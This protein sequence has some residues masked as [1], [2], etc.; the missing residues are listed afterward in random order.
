MLNGQAKPAPSSSVH[1]MNVAISVHD[2]SF[3]PT[4]AV[5]L[6]QFLVGGDTIVS[7]R[8]RGVQRVYCL[9]RKCEGKLG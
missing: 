4:Q 9:Q 3:R 2:S 5:G 8:A 7:W 6:A 1:Q